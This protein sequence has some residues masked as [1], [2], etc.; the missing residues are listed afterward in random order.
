MH[1]ESHAKVRFVGF[2]GK[3]SFGP[4]L[5]GTSWIEAAAWCCMKQAPTSTMVVIT[6]V[7]FAKRLAG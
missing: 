1:H 4:V 6:R 2:K 3:L 7:M 5:Q